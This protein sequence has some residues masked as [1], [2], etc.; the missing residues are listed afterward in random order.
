MTEYYRTHADKVVDA[1]AAHP[2]DDVISDETRTLT[3]SEF[4]DL[5]TRLTHVLAGQGLTRGNTVAILAPITI[6]AIA[7]RYAATRLG[8]VT[9]LCPDAGTP[10]RLSVFLSRINADVVIA[11]PDTALGI[12]PISAPIVLAIGSIPGVPTDLLALTEDASTDSLR[13]DIDESYPCVLVATG[14][15][16]GVSKASVRSVGAY[17]RLVD[18]GPTPGRRQ[19]ICTPLPYIAQTLV[20]TVMIGGGQLVLRRT[21]EP[22]MIAHTIAE[23][24]V[25]HVALVEPLLVE[26]LDGI[27]IAHYDLSSLI[28]ISHIG[29]DASPALRRRL[30]GRAG[31]NFLVHP[32]GA[33]EFGVVSALAG[34]EYSLDR[35]ELLSAAGKPIPSVEIRITDAEGNVRPAGDTGLITV[36]T[37]AMA[38]GYSVEPP[39]SGFRDDGW[40]TTGDAG[41]LDDAG[42]L[43][44]RGRAADERIINGRSVFPLDVQEALC[45]DPAVAYAV[46]VPDP[47]GGFGAAAVLAA[48]ATADAGDLAEH[49]RA[50]SD[51][52][53]PT[54]I[55]VVDH[56]PTTEQGKPHRHHVTDLI[57]PDA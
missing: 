44:I 8:C 26:L 12:T 46:A 34:P 3:G 57:W 51:E 50:R 41:Y 5:I 9:V 20:D 35:P 54:T 2:S 25:T 16:T 18:L 39:S 28:A 19:L 23:K 27:D 17:N 38:Q 53:P 47:G 33:S 7:V 49:L 36:R 45:S 56:I 14:G 37:T 10:E 43:H 42:Y 40:F 31:R 24:R 6:E 4:L 52:A 13:V 15:T 30:L 22:E 21:F 32:Y 11:F 55:V 48:G 1:L 29:A